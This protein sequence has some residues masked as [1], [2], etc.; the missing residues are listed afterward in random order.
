MVSDKLMKKFLVNMSLDPEPISVVCKRLGLTAEGNARRT[1]VA[2][3]DL[4]LVEKVP[5]SCSEYRFRQGW[6]KTEHVLKQRTKPK[7]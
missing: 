4:G 1:L 5:I 6:A 3:Q 2:M 7:Y